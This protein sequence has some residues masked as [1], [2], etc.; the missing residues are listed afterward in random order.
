MFDLKLTQVKE[1]FVKIFF[2]E[3]KIFEFDTVGKLICY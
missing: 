2:K 1:C 3:I